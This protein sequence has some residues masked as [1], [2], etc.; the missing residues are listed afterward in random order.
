LTLAALVLTG[1]TAD[2]QSRRSRHAKARTEKRVS[3]RNVRRTADDASTARVATM[4]TVAGISMGLTLEEDSQP[5]TR[6]EYVDGLK[7][8]HIVWRDADGNIVNEIEEQDVP[9]PYRLKTEVEVE[10]KE[11]VP[12]THKEDLPFAFVEDMPIFP[13]GEAALMEFVSS[14]LN[15]PPEAAKKNVQ[16]SVYVR[17]VVEKDGSIGDVQVLRSIESSLDKEAK[18]VVKTLPNFIPGRQNGEVVRVWYTLPITF[19]LPDSK[20]AE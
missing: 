2:A 12:M 20:T 3:K 18:R 1:T 7:V 13:G 8:K 17:F 11:E 14:H 15:Y 10:R 9:S 16:G 5:L 19:I 6:E 4:D